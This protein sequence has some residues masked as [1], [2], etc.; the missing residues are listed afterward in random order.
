MSEAK[1]TNAQSRCQP[2]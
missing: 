2:A 1:F